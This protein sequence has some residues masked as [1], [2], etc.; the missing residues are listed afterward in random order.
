MLIQELYVAIQDTFTNRFS[1]HV[2]QRIFE[3]QWTTMNVDIMAK[4]QSVLVGKW[5]DIANDEN[6][7]LIVQCIFEHCKYSDKLPIIA[8]IFKCT[9]DISRG[10]S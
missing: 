9:A 10:L 4:V 2:W 7:S 5:A 6:G 1:C 8:E 3:V